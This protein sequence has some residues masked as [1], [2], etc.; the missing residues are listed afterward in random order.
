MASLVELM[1]LR[2]R[3]S[4]LDEAAQ[5]AF[6]TLRSRDI[7]TCI[8]AMSIFRQRSEER[9]ENFRTKIMGKK[10][11]EEEEAEEEEDIYKR[12]PPP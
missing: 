11:E 9:C 4:L 10:E 3:S 6:A 1:R 8:T 7:S 2:A 5:Y 12:G